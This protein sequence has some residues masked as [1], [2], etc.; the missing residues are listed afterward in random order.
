MPDLLCTIRREI[1]PTQLHHFMNSYISKSSVQK[2]C[3]IWEKLFPHPREHMS[4]S[5]STHTPIPNPVIRK[6]TNGVDYFTNIVRSEQ[7]D[8]VS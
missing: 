2:I 5:Y 8:N 6:H 3:T 4:P 7:N 1:S